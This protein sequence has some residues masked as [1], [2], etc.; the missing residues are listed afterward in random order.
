MMLEARMYGGVA[1]P[2]TKLQVHQ[3]GAKFPISKVYIDD[4]LLDPNMFYTLIILPE[5]ARLSKEGTVLVL[6]QFHFQRGPE[7]L[8]AFPADLLSNDAKEACLEWLA[9][10]KQPEF[11]TASKGKQVGFNYLF[12]VPSNVRKGGKE[13][14]M[15]S[16][17]TDSKQVASIEDFLES[18]LEEQISKM[19]N[20]LSV[21][22]EQPPEPKTELTDAQKGDLEKE[23]ELV[24]E[25]IRAHLKEIKANIDRTLEI[26]EKLE[27][28]GY[29]GKKSK[30]LKVIQGDSDQVAIIKGVILTVQ[31]DQGPVPESVL[32][33]EEDGVHVYKREQINE[34]KSHT[35]GSSTVLQ[36][37]KRSM[38]LLAEERDGSAHDS[39][40][41]FFGILPYPDIKMDGFTYFFSIPS[42]NTSGNSNGASITV[43]VPNSSKSFFYKHVEEMRLVVLDHT[44]R[45]SRMLSHD[46]FASVMLDLFKDLNDFID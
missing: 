37:S 10:G 46:A 30:E 24:H 43:L 42:P 26:Q 17:V 33:N 1:I 11:F 25:K 45:I 8:E 41:K 29:R 13:S 20:E 39:T 7:I 32:L 36:V 14:F 4:E 3:N 35:I 40:I 31:E 12:E 22:Q 23:N 5:G 15:L 44:R 2:H 6:T 27:D 34:I 9:S 18:I 28:L 19:Q 38:A 21:F 16:L